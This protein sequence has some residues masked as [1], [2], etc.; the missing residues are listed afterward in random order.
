MKKE[1][2]NFKALYRSGVAFYHLGDYD[3]ALY[4]LKE[5]RTRQPTGKAEMDVFSSSATS[6][7][8]WGPLIGM[9]SSHGA[10]PGRCR[11]GKLGV[12]WPLDSGMR[13]TYSPCICLGSESQGTWAPLPFKLNME[14]FVFSNPESSFLLLFNKYIL[15]SYD[16]PRFL[17]GPRDVDEKSWL[18]YLRSSHSGGQDRIQSNDLGAEPSIFQEACS[19]FSSQIPFLRG[20]IICSILANSRPQ[21]QP[22]VHSTD[23]D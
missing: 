9:G 1:G 3:K 22:F 10:G 17:L 12:R 8:S 14:F 5:A 13:R 4:Y 6:G 7:S 16:A 21:A 2:E 19:A 18:V 20:C 11:N 15:N 23:T